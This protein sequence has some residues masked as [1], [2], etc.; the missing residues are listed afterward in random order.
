M[1]LK[2][3]W[4]RSTDYWK[5]PSYE[6]SISVD[7]KD[8]LAL[9]QYINEHLLTQK[10]CEDS[11]G[12]QLIGSFQD[13]PP[14][15]PSIGHGS[16]L[17][18]EKEVGIY[19]FRSTADTFATV[20]VAIPFSGLER[21]FKADSPVDYDNAPWLEDVNPS[22]K[23]MAQNVF[24]TFDVHFAI[25]GEEAYGSFLSDYSYDFE[26]AILNEHIVYFVRISSVRITSEILKEVKHFKKRNNV[27]VHYI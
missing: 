23:M 12:R 14:D 22:L 3:I 13:L 25:I 6:L 19:M 11:R 18:A 15:T 17:L 9:I 27:E 20:N 2:S 4:W 21:F 26:A 16:L 5:G 8:E 7:K 24:N 1:K 10:L